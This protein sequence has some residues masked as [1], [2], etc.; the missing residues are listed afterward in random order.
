MVRKK[1]DWEG[2]IKFFLNGIASVS[3]ESINTAKEILKMK[4]EH[5]DMVSDGVR[6]PANGLKLL[7]NMFEHPIITIRKVEE[8]LN[9]GTEIIK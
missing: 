6:N 7:E 2:W 9:A 3:D 8:L 1:G 4:E 5:T